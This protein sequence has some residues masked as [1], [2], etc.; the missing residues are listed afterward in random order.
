[1][2]VLKVA[3][4]DVSLVVGTIAPGNVRLN[5]DKV[6][7]Y[8]V[9]MGL[10]IIVE[11]VLVMHYAKRVVRL[12]ASVLRA[13]LNVELIILLHALLVVECPVLRVPVL[14]FVIMLAS[15]SALLVHLIVPMNV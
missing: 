13:N 10:R 14:Q 12:V 2:S 11:E 1:M 4:M 9:L 5:V 8:L 15:L 3:G 6:V 7:R